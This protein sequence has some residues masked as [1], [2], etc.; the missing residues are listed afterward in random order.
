MPF[1][2]RVCVVDA[3]S[4]FVLPWSHSTK[5]VFSEWAE[6]PGELSPVLGWD[7]AGWEALNG[8]A[9]R[10]AWVKTIF[11]YTV[12][13]QKAARWEIAQLV[14]FVTTGTPALR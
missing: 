11:E 7:K 10:N 9:R 4:V 12:P 5:F 14:D 2:A 3:F 6:I 1:H 13:Q 8:W